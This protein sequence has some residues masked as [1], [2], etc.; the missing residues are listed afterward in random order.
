[1]ADGEFGGEALLTGVLQTPCG[2][3]GI[4]L[5]GGRL[6]S[7][8]WF[9]E[10]SASSEG[11]PALVRIADQIR[12]YFRDPQVRFRCRLDVS[13]SLFCLRVWGAL[14]NIPPGQT[15]TYGQLARQL[16]VSPRAV[17]AACRANPCPIVIPCHRV[18]AQ[19]GLGGYG[20]GRTPALLAVKR[21]LLR[22]EGWH[23]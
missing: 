11:S 8:E 23:G 16:D 6:V 19:E 18:V 12:A 13:T 10:R 22:H 17:A 9:P 7:L 4:T 3:L 15:R 1:M 21:C 20:G 5:R 2:P 14:L